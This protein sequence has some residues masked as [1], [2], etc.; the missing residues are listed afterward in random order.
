MER[1]TTIPYF[2]MNEEFLIIRT[3]TKRM[4]A[5]EETLKILNDPDDATLIKALKE[6]IETIKNIILKLTGEF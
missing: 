3:L 4:Q 6:N 1:K 2:T 5:H